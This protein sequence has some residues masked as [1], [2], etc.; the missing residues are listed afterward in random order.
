[1]LTFNWNKAELEADFQNAGIVETGLSLEELKT[2]LLQIAERY[3]V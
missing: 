1:M 3:H 2:G